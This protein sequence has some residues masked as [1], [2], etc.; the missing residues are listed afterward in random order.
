MGEMRP[1]PRAMPPS[2][3]VRAIEVGHLSID[4]RLEIIAA[5]EANLEGETLGACDEVVALIN[6][7]HEMG[8]AMGDDNP[9]KMSMTDIYEQ[10]RELKFGRGSILAFTRYIQIMRSVTGM[11]CCL[12]TPLIWGVRSR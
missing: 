2:A 12:R 5:S 3:V 10:A 7:T 4:E 11:P 9:F 1:L 6:I 8:K